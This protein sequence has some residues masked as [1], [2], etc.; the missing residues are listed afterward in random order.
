ME[1][2]VRLEHTLVAVERE[3]V[4]HAMVELAA[5]EAPGHDRRP[6]LKLALVIDRSGSMAGEKL[7][8]TKACAAYLVRR[9]SPTDELAVV[10]YDD[11]VDLVA[12]LA[13]VQTENLIPALAAIHPGGSTNS[14]AAG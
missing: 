3:Q 12:P 7:E 9:L 10:A 2:T 6:A 5:P 4:V 11:A 8:V 14:R 13:P 1:P